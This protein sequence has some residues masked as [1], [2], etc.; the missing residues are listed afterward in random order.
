MPPPS[1]W[2]RPCLPISRPRKSSVGVTLGF[3]SSWERFQDTRISLGFRLAAGIVCGCAFTPFFGPE[4][5]ASVPPEHTS[6][7]ILAALI[8][9]LEANA[10][11]PVLELGS[12]PFEMAQCLAAP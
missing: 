2:N 4:S 6:I 9:H 8:V 10:P 3:I 7:G 1:A 12:P 5:A 11:T